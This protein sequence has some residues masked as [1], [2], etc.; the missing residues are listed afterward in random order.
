M[1][2]WKRIGSR[3]LEVCEWGESGKASRVGISTCVR[4]DGNLGFLGRDRLGRTFQ[5]EQRYEA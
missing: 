4:T 1:V 2:P 3:A 5:T